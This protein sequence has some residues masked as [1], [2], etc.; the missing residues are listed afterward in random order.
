MLDNIVAFERPTNITEAF[1]AIA[2]GAVPVSGG[3][4]V[5]LH[6]RRS[7]TTLVDLTGLPLAGIS[8]VE[9]NIVVGAT[10][11]MTEML[12]H[13]ETAAVANGVIAQMLREVG[14]PLL[15]NVATIGGHVARG[16]LSDVIPVLLALDST[17]QFHDGSDKSE[18]LAG[19]YAREGHREPL[20]VTG[21]TIPVPQAGSAAA[22]RKFSR[23]RFDLAILNAA[24]RV[25]LDG[26]TVSAA[27]IVVGETPALGASLA[28]CEASLVGGPLD[29][30]AI[31]RC[32]T[33]AASAVP[34]RDDDRASA[35]YRRTLGAVLV[36][37][38]LRDAAGRLR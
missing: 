5:I 11:T 21:V 6:R 31:E 2:N 12:H 36:R 22:F 9:N 14:S 18:S 15:R 17:I 29:E 35:E 25:D 30:S 32:A 16:R 37:R 13:A 8:R 19:F 33:V 4:D 28:A 27:R 20:I 10:T 1:A 7:P 34:A 23:T 26:E 38:C 3:T 24:C